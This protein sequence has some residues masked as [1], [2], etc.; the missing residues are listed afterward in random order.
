MGTEIPDFHVEIWE[1]LKNDRVVIA[2]PRGFSKSTIISKLYP[3]HLALFKLRRDITIISASETLATEHLR[4]IKTELESNQMILAFFGDL[5]SEKWTEN[6]IVVK[7]KDGTR[8][9]IRAKGAGGQIR[10]FRPDVIILD[11][12]ETD[13]SV[14][15]EEQRKKLKS[16][17]L[18]ACINTL[19][20]GGQLAFIGTV[21]HPLSILADFL[22]VPNG[23]FKK[24]YTAY[25]DGIQEKGHELWPKER[26]HE[27]LKQRK[28]DIGTWAFAAEF[29][30][31]PKTDESAPIKDHHIRYWTEAPSQMNVVIAVDPAYSE[32][33]KADFKVASVI[34]TD[35]NNNRYLLEYLRTHDS[36]GD[37][38]DGLLNLYIRYKSQCTALGIPNS[39]TEKSFF[40]SVVDRAGERKLYPPIVELKNAAISSTGGSVRNK[41]HRIIATLQPIFEQGRYYIHN[42]HLEARE[43]LLT[44]GSSRW[45][46][47]VDTMSYA[48]QIVTPFFGELQ[49][50]SNQKSW[51]GKSSGYGIEY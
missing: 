26:P 30:N 8:V 22:E 44:I 19:L 41:K 51:A 3:L 37:F 15:S 32:D 47:V 17:L 25:K 11:D 10:G 20:P 9:N 12:I 35:Q 33:V 1:S 24:K 38:I 5:R 36:L 46:D 48:E 18:K 23:W 7:H 29:M 43:E 2:A 34:G 14:E 4:W 16:W 31:D 6:H 27:W 21:I 49:E 50:S 13:E 28:L 45:D 39:G 42:T 40:K